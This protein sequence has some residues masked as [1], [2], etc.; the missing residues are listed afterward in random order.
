MVTLIGTNSIT[1]ERESQKMRESYLFIIRK[2]IIFDKLVSC[3]PQK[4]TTRPN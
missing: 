1:A 2:A 4:N 3:G